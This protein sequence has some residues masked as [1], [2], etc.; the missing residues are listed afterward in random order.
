MLFFPWMD[1]PGAKK[2]FCFPPCLTPSSAGVDVLVQWSGP[3]GAC[4]RPAMSPE[5]HSVCQGAIVNEG[6]EG[7]TL[8][9]FFQ[10]L[11]MGCDA[12]PRILLP[13][14]RGLCAS[15]Q[16]PAQHLFTFEIERWIRSTRL[17]IDGLFIIYSCIYVLA[18]QS[19]FSLVNQVSVH[20]YS[21]EIMQMLIFSR[22]TQT[23]TLGGKSA[24]CLLR[25]CLSRDSWAVIH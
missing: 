10:S 18:E 19:L 7:Q 6:P 3:S 20:R 25:S 12:I 21:G 2:G 4:D 23:E 17:T 9:L 8:L 24:V 13:S 14:R 22:A 1:F 15:V 16:C 11:A 5:G